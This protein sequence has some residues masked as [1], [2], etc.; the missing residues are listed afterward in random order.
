MLE[1]IKEMLKSTQ[2][3]TLTFL[4]LPQQALY[5]DF[6]SNWLTSQTTSNSVVY[7]SS[8]FFQL[9]IKF[10]AVIVY[11]LQVYPRVKVSC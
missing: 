5:M 8:F 10:D 1:E 7:L 2:V 11:F 9:L 3:H 6:I 4:A